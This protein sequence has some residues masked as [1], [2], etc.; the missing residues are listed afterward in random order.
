MHNSNIK[1]INDF[2]IPWNQ[3]AAK[4]PCIFFANNHALPCLFLFTITQTSHVENNRWTLKILQE[5]SRNTVKPLLIAAHAGNCSEAGQWNRS[6]TR[7]VDR[8]IARSV[9]EPSATLC[10]RWVGAHVQ[11]WCPPVHRSWGEIVRWLSDHQLSVRQIMR[12]RKWHNR[13]AAGRLLWNDT[14]K[15]NL[16]ISVYIL[17]IVVFW[18][19]W[20]SM[21]HGL[22]DFLL[23]K[24]CHAWIT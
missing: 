6:W 3:Y 2:R 22:S 16:N 18:F 12:Y 8:P 10:Q 15:R 7:W 9:P 14:V 13:A 21:K 24:C 23:P 4:S 20:L 17:C 19:H 1:W 11:R 5:P